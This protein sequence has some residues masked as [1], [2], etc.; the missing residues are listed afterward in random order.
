M[1]RKGGKGKGGGKFIKDENLS[2]GEAEDERAP[3][4][5]AGSL[6][7]PLRRTLNPAEVEQRGRRRSG[8]RGKTV[9]KSGK[10][11]KK[12]GAEDTPLTGAPPSTNEFTNDHP[13]PPITN[14]GMRLIHPA[15]YYL[16][17]PPNA[18][19]YAGPYHGPPPPAYAGPYHAYS[20]PPYAGPPPP[21][22]A[23]PPTLSGPPPPYARPYTSTTE[24]LQEYSASSLSCNK[25]KLSSCKLFHDSCESYRIHA[26]PPRRFMR[27][28]LPPSPA[29]SPP[30]PPLLPSLL[31]S[32][33]PPLPDSCMIHGAAAWEELHFV[34]GHS[35]YVV[36]PHYEG[37]RAGGPYEPPPRPRMYAPVDDS[38]LASLLSERGDQV[39]F[40]QLC[41]FRIVRNTLKTG[42]EKDVWFVIYLI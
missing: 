34:T 2:K 5:L 8:K 25:V 7:Q 6:N 40:C 39:P 17:Y 20:Q 13:A 21:P 16:D 38:G 11:G 32:P 41:L 29:I 30:P 35:S 19:P 26:N 18:A 9:G 31:P 1:P 3:G 28:P 4:Q 14:E 36:D 23:G 24:A 42:K 10:H 27:I 33:L 12:G 22:Y 15:D 37:G